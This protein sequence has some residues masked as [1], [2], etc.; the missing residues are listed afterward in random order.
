MGMLTAANAAKATGVGTSAPDRRQDFL[1]TIDGLVYGDSPDQGFIRGRVFS[2]P[3]LGFTFTVPD[4]FK[5]INRPDAVLA[6][7]PSSSAIVFNGVQVAAR[8]DPRTYLVHQWAPSVRLSDVERITINGME[9]A[10]GWTRLNA[11]G[12]LVDVRLVVIRYSDRQFFRF[13]F[14]TPASMTARLKRD[15]ERTT[16]SFRRL[17]AKEAA[18]LKPLRIRVV[19]VRT[20]DTT[21]SLARRMRVDEAPLDWFRV[22]NR[23]KPGQNP[24]VGSRIKLVEE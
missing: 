13:Q 24:P 21:Q 10:T 17:S 7:G 11:Q 23:L 20:G 12:S 2:H 18:A 16:Y 3:K 5:L 4:G 8:T 14:V 6:K 19:T 22:L 15:L 9:G 1:N